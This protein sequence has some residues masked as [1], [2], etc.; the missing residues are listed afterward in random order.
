MCACV[1]VCV[2]VCVRMCTCVCVVWVCVWLCGCVCAFVLAHA[3]ICMINLE[4]YTL[5]HN[6]MLKMSR[7]LNKGHFGDIINPADLFY[8]G[9]P[10]WKVQV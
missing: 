9:F 10:F 6:N 5:L 4:L 3:L 8:V 2:C 1:C 7:T